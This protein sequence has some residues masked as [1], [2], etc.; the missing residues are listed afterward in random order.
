MRALLPGAYDDRNRLR[1]PPV[2]FNMSEFNR[3][4]EVHFFTRF[5][6]DLYYNRVGQ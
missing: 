5:L 1:V 6:S 3:L 2:P 4:H